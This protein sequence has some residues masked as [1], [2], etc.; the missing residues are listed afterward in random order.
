[1]SNVYNIIKPL[2]KMSD[3]E[4]KEY[5]YKIRHR[6]NVIRPAA[7][8]IQKVAKKKSNQKINK[9]TQLLL[10]LNPIDLE[11]LLKEIEK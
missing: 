11:S 5:L 8:A 6:K 2:E 7:K 4:L 1:M 9:A 3:Q 10:N